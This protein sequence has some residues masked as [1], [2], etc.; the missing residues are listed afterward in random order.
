VVPTEL[1]NPQLL[2]EFAAQNKIDLVTAILRKH[3]SEVIGLN[4][5]LA[6]SSQVMTETIASTPLASI[7]GG[8]ARLS[9]PR[10]MA[11]INYGM[12]DPPK[13]VTNFSNSRARLTLLM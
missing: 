13:V 11:W 8:M 2:V 3:P 10:S 4:T 6:V 7:H 12:I 1:T 9:G 5:E